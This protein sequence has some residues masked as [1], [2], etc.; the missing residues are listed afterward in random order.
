MFVTI[1]LFP[2]SCAAAAADRFTL[3]FFR[4]DMRQSTADGVETTRSLILFR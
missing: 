4:Q 2:S 3:F 1:K